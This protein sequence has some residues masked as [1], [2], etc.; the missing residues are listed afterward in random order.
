[1][2]SIERIFNLFLVVARSIRQSY[3]E[4]IQLTSYPHDPIQ[5]IEPRLPITTFHKLWDTKDRKYVLKVLESMVQDSLGRNSPWIWYSYI[6]QQYFYATHPTIAIYINLK[7]CNRDILPSITLSSGDI[8]ECM[9]LFIR[10][11]RY[12]STS[13]TIWMELWGSVLWH[14]GSLQDIIM[15][16]KELE[17][18]QDI[19][20]VRGIH[21]RSSS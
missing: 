3:S 19:M 11:I 21:I 1:M 7:R 10:S 9:K 16:Q 15:N 8:Q 2:T 4:Y 6:R 14:V 17:D 20:N 12:N 18:M 5:T 13:K